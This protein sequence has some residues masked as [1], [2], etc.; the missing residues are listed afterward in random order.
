[1][2]RIVFLMSIWT[3]SVW[4]ADLNKAYQEGSQTATSH[5]NQST[6]LLKSLNLSEFPGYESHV[7]QENYYQ[8]VT[9][10]GTR[11]EADAQKP[12]ELNQEVQQSFNQLPYYQMNMQTARMQQLNQIAEHGDEIMQGKDTQQ[13]KCSLQPK[14]CQYSWQE[15]TCRVGKQLGTLSCIQQ[16][17]IDLLHHKTEQ[18]TLYLRATKHQLSYKMQVNWSQP[19]TCKQGIIPCYILYKDGKEALPSALNAD[20]AM[21]KLGV[22]DSKGYTTLQEKPTCQKNSFTLS[23]GKCRLGYCQVPYTHSVN[24][25]WEVYQGQEYW[26]D[27]CTSLV[28][29]EQKGSCHLKEAL[30]CIESNQKRIIGELSYFRACWKKKAVYQ[31]GQSNTESCD[32]LKAQGCDQIN[33]RCVE[34]QESKCV[35]FEQRFQCPIKQ[36]TDN[37]LICGQEAFCL[38]G[39]CSAHDY[40]PSNDADFKKA[41][42]ALSAASQAP[43]EFNGASNFLFKGQKLE[44]SDDMMG[45]KNCCRDS[46]WG[47]DLNLAHCTD[48]EKQLGQAKENKLVVATGSYCYK[49]VKLPIGSV[50][51]STHKTYCV[52]QSKL[53]RIIQEQGRYK[54]LHIDFGHGKHSNCVGITPQQL[55][56]IHFESIDFSEFYQDIQDKQKQPDWQKTTKGI[57][58]RIND[59]YQQGEVNG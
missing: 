31:C 5:A 14:Q 44:C 49:R 20:C 23:V 40:Q 15:K 7:P 38:D 59:F 22:S 43:Q 27:Q 57:S 21:V 53:A 34:Q 48:S 16:L 54:Q 2:K 50:C 36:C 24:L 25:S 8:G 13:T 58:Q 19:N 39:N 11:L 30:K 37:Q 28:Q 52:F 47:I 32:V 3:F 26:D 46:G 9:Q 1:M 51:K 42:A 6:E 17:H 18:Y 10:Q 4:A 29:Q 41:I 35:L 45:F 33:S 55:Q 12:N 56:L